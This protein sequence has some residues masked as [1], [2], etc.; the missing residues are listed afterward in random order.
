MGQ[1]GERKRQPMANVKGLDSDIKPSMDEFNKTTRHNDAIPGPIP[2][3]NLRNDAGT[4]TRGMRQTR[5]RGNRRG[6][7]FG[8]FGYRQRCSIMAREGGPSGYP[9]FHCPGGLDINTCDKIREET[10]RPRL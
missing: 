1:K 3:K 7:G 9:C 5:F 4:R 10:G 6:N 8:V 2:V